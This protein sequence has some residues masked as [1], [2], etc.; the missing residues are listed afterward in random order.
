[1]A[2]LVSSELVEHC[3]ESNAVHCHKRYI[4]ANI[5]TFVPAERL[6]IANFHSDLDYLVSQI[7]IRCFNSVIIQPA[8][9]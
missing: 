2:G 4:R 3:R 1:M 6:N 8:A 7:C 5:H 9:A